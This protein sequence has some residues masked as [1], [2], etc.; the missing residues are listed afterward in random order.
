MLF[1]GRNH[2]NHIKIQI[3][4]RK[5]RI[6][7]HL[8]CDEFSE[9]KINTILSKDEETIL[10][11]LNRNIYVFNYCFIFRAIIGIASTQMQTSKLETKFSA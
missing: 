8:K 3:E 6:T 2:S 10:R 11:L 7:S 4:N 1:G 5:N 9:L